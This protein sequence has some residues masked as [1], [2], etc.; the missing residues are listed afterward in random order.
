MHS[1]SLCACLEEAWVYICASSPVYCVALFQSAGIPV[2]VMWQLEGDS[3]HVPAGKE[4]SRCGRLEMEQD[5]EG[6]QFLVILQVWGHCLTGR[7]ICFLHFDILAGHV[8]EG[9]HP[10]SVGV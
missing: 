5:P 7:E 6:K 3:S 2:P 8:C 4:Y 1:L 10:H 9:L